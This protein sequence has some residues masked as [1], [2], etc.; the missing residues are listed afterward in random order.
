M[1][2]ADQLLHL[3]EL[4]AAALLSISAD[5]S[6]E[7]DKSPVVGKLTSDEQV[8]ATSRSGTEVYT[9]CLFR[10]DEGDSVGRKITVSLRVKQGADKSFGQRAPVLVCMSVDP[11]DIY[12][13]GVL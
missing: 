13:S 3:G 12:K 7:L 2:V 5:A 9:T 8:N 10:F 6:H 1:F 11:V 4:P